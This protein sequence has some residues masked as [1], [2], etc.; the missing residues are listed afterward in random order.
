M[1]TYVCDDIH[2][3]SVNKHGLSRCPDPRRLA[4]GYNPIRYIPFV[5][6]ITSTVRYAT[7]C[8]DELGMACSVAY[9]NIP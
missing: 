6:S 5:C 7:L 3:L 4:I 2:M 1:Y 8:K 9:N